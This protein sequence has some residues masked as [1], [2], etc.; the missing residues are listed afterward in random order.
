M[1]SVPAEGQRQMEQDSDRSQQAHEFV[2][3]GY[4]V[5]KDEQ[6]DGFIT[7]RV[8]PGFN[9]DVPKKSV[10][11]LEEARDEVTGRDYIKITFDD[12]QEIHAS[13]QPR[14]ARLAMAVDGGVPFA[15]GGDFSAHVN[16]QMPPGVGLPGHPGAP[17]QFTP[18]TAPGGIPPR[19]GLPF[20][21]DDGIAPIH[22]GTTTGPVVPQVPPAAP[23]Q[24]SVT[25]YYMT[26]VLTGSTMSKDIWGSLVNDD[27]QPDQSVDST[28]MD[29]QN[30]PSFWG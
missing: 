19:I 8:F 10:K 16:P 24:T 4:L 28:S 1:R 22:S 3:H 15:F 17:I 13:F 23:R 20:L 2:L 18:Q 12:S 5:K 14:L 21:N 30:D 29:Y 27:W 9:V 7:I 11:N 6:E 26:Q 25:T